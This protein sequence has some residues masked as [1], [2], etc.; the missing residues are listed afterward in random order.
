MSHSWRHFR[1]INATRQNRQEKKTVP[2]GNTGVGNGKQ[3]S[4]ILDNLYN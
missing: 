4:K 2:H 1:Q 3:P